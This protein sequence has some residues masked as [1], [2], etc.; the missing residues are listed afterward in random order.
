MR[1]K[2]G[3]RSRDTSHPLLAI[4]TALW[5]QQGECWGLACSQDKVT[6]ATGTERLSTYI[7]QH[8]ITA[9]LL[10]LLMWLAKGLLIT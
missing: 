10:N 3:T 6:L 7:Q 1:D 2:L 4:K 9:I 5:S 8:Q